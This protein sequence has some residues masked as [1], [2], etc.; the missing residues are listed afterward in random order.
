[1]LFL[2]VWHFEPS[3]F[4]TCTSDR[5][6]RSRKALLYTWQLE[7]GLA[8]SRDRHQTYT[9]EAGL[10]QRLGEN[11][12]QLDVGLQMLTQNRDD[13]QA[14]ALLGQAVV[15]RPH[16]LVLDDLSQKFFVSRI[17]LN[18]ITFRRPLSW[19]SGIPSFAQAVHSASGHF[20]VPLPQ[21]R[22]VFHHHGLGKNK[23]STNLNAN[24]ALL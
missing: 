15:A 17:F 10:V 14:F 7:L 18:I 20:A 12:L 5:L 13:V 11:A 9:A 1:M 23:W 3:S 8:Q 24:F 16:E 6:F 19:T 21:A 22:H 2:K 4:T